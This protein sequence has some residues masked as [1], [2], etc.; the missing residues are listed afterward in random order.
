MLLEGLPRQ[1]IRAAESIPGK[2]FFL[3]YG[4]ARASGAILKP[5][6]I[7]LKILSELAK[8]GQKP[9]FFKRNLC[10]SAHTG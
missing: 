6:N 2:L 7:D 5:P 10:S 4:P 9:V 3:I 1:E 8:T